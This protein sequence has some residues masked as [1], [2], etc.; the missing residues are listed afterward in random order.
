M[1]LHRLSIQNLA[2]L[3]SDTPIEID[4]DAGLKGAPLFAIVGATGAGKST[5]LDAIQL[6]LFG[7][8]A[9]L[10]DGQASSKTPEELG[11]TDTR[12]LI[13]RGARNAHVELEFGLVDAQGVARR[14]LATWSCRLPRTN[15]D[16]PERTIAEYDF[17]Q[18]MWGPARG[19]SKAKDYKDLFAETLGGMTVDEFNRTILLAQGQF[20]ALLHAKKDE[21][22]AL[23]EKVTQTRQ[24]REIGARAAQRYKEAKAAYEQARDLLGAMQIPPPE[25]EDEL[26]AELAELTRQIEAHTAE[27]N[28][29]SGR[30]AWI[31]QH[32]SLTVDI[33]RAETALVAVAN[34]RE[35]HADD[36]ARLRDAIHVQDAIARM[37]QI[38]DLQR[39]LQQVVA[40]IAAV[41][42]ERNERAQAANAAI[43]TEQTAQALL[44]DAT[45]QRD[46][47]LPEI[48]EAEAAWKLA[49]ERNTQYRNASLEA[50]NAASA[51]TK[52]AEALANAEAALTMC[53]TLL[54]AHDAGVQD[55]IALLDSSRSALTAL[56]GPLASADEAM[57]GARAE[58]ENAANEAR[59]ASDARDALGECAKASAE[60]GT[61]LT[62]REEQNTAIAT[63]EA[64]LAEARE[65]EEAAKTALTTAQSHAELLKRSEVFVENRPALQDGEPCPLCGSKSHDVS[66]FPHDDE[67]RTQIATAQAA[68]QS[69]TAQREACTIR[70]ARLENTLTRLRTEATAAEAVQTRAQQV[71][72][73]RSVRY[74]ALAQALGTTAD[75]LS[76]DGLTERMALAMDRA[77]RATARIAELQAANKALTQAEEAVSAADRE[78]NRLQLELT[79]ATATRNTLAGALNDA[80]ARETERGA[81]VEEARAALETA[82]GACGALLGGRD[83][84]KVREAL[85]RAFEAAQAKVTSATEMRL[86]AESAVNESVRAIGLL[87]E[88]Q[89]KRAGEIEVAEAGLGLLLSELGVTREEAEARRLHRD[90]RARIEQIAAALD[91]DQHG[92]TVALEAARKKLVDHEAACPEGLDAASAEVDALTEARN[93]LEHDRSTALSEV[94]ARKQALAEIEAV[95][96]RAAHY[97][98]QVEA[99]TAELQAWERIYNVIGI[100]EGAAFARFAQSL[101]LEELLWRANE[102][103]HFLNPRY[104]FVRIGD[105]LDFGVRDHDQLDG[106][107]P[108]STLSGGETFLCS[109]ALALG[110]AR[111]RVS[112]IPIETLLLDEGFGTLD[113]ETLNVAMSALQRLCGGGNMRVGV[114]THVEAMRERIDARIVVEKRHG[115]RSTVRL[116]TGLR[117]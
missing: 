105:N 95:R 66:L 115:G 97:L 65:A 1:R 98:A 45:R 25:R 55:R 77:K 47:A 18:D 30:I 21:R 100:G 60:L 74:A 114:V 33:A 35:A 71:R 37:D 68:M 104:S 17:K 11:A 64:E 93:Q 79:S 102:Q 48:A 67:L 16:A 92:A 76:H 84:G 49:A 73:E 58:K 15:F 31:G 110:L 70:I 82:Q 51:A 6:A 85:Q 56:L 29:V 38:A 94:G 42:H 109:L 39:S 23:L 116:E 91:R 86:K 13:S 22:V 72:D 111:W 99:A 96:K 4:F 19:G 61:V 41:Q 9:R 63:S 8:T 40:Q 54:E 44:T 78:R 12:Q 75:Q 10:A 24:Y 81:A 69:A 3:R 80:R 103:L 43:A 88:Q 59:N 20:A 101:G 87:T 106:I 14:Y 52:A 34:R 108:L 112:S 113:G 27:V 53:Q 57:E 89:A 36:L 32:T 7:S 5:I 90:E 50:Q 46:D 62:K 107:R 117:T 28:R 26:R 2:S 83:P